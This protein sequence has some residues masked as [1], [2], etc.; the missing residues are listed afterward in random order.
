MGG[1]GRRFR[2]CCPTLLRFYGTPEEVGGSIDPTRTPQFA[3][4]APLVRMH[5]PPW[6]PRCT[7]SRD[8]D[9]TEL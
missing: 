6:R 3:M 8:T 5:A 1:Q 4:A 7:D 2:K 9:T